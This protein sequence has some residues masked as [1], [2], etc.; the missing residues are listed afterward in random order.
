M[1][2]AES[3]Y[4]NTAEKMNKALLELLEKK[5]FEYI[6]VRELCREAGVNRSTFYLHYETI[7][8]LLAET[9]EYINRSFLDYMQKDAS[10]VIGRLETCPIEELDLITPDYLVPYLDFI[11]E[12][13]RLYCTAIKNSA[14]LQL[15]KS[16]DG[17]FRY[18]FTP[19]LERFNVP[20]GDRAYIMDYFIH[21]LTAIIDRWLEGGCADSCER[22]IGL[23][24]ACVRSGEIID[25]KQPSDGE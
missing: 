12:H 10:A 4:F 3:R 20:E 14:L 13:R 15:D 18:V 17:M 1:N 19:I 2:K 22:I 24:Q 16:Y 7:A 5:D 6:T 23:I 21:G 9:T 11:K 8:D 25:Q